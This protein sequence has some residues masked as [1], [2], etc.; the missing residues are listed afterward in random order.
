MFDKVIT[1]I[2]DSTLSLL[3][4]FDVDSC[5]FAYDYDKQTVCTT[6][7]GM[8]ALKYAVNVVD[9]RFG[10]ACYWRRLEKYSERGFA[11]GVPG[12]LKER[13][14]KSMEGSYVL[15]QQYGLLLK[16][17]PV[18]IGTEKIINYLDPITQQSET[19]TLKA[20]AEQRGT[21]IKDLLRLIIL[22]GG[23]AKHVN[24]PS[25][26]FCEKHDRIVCDGKLS[27][28]C[29]PISTGSGEYDLLWGIEPIDMQQHFEDDD[30]EGYESTQLATICGILDKMFLR[31]STNVTPDGWFT[32]GVMQ[33]LT[34]KMTQSNT[35][36]VY[37]AAL[38]S[39]SNR[40]VLGNPLHFVYDI[41]G[42][43]TRFEALKYVLDA[44]QPPLRN[45]TNFEKIYGLPRHL[46]FQMK[47]T[48]VGVDVD[49]FESVY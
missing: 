40:S 25:R 12:L 33:K 23:L 29:M 17:A 37:K 14:S 34:N 5:C 9:T 21:I 15:V 35:S 31:D 48:R 24:I 8:R 45:D 42:A 32:G 26:W 20:I 10:S 11:I 28:S 2:I 30:I 16:V 38:E 4:D 18:T 22:D 19:V 43:E 46:R 39:N 7:R 27:G 1:G 41:V 44:A 3:L 47:T 36:G 6:P 49:I 13:I